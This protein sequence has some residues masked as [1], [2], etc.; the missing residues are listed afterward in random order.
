M[1]HR[2]KPFS[3]ELPK[4]LKREKRKKP[5]Q[6]AITIRIS[7]SEKKQM[8]KHTHSTASSLSDILREA[9]DSWKFKRNRLCMEE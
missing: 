4:S 1:S 6:N 2:K 8:E 7:D 5:L 3:S 9:L